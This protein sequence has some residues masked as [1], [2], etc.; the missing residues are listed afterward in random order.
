MAL[1]GGGWWTR[2]TVRRERRS[3]APQVPPPVIREPEAAWWQAHEEPNEPPAEEPAPPAVTVAV[4]REGET[5]EAVVSRLAELAVDD[6]LLV[7]YGS[8]SCS[9]PGHHAVI[10][11]LRGQLPRHHVVAV[12]VR[13]RDGQLRRDDAAALDR[14]LEM[15]SLPVVVA[16]AAFMHGITAE[17]SSYL[18]ADRVLRVLRTTTG[19]DLCQVW[20][21]HPELSV[22]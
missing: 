12:D 11:G 3:P 6:E 14:F 1:H 21:R 8:G 19:A 2:R 4:V 7:V 10:A 18:R 17:I 13:H 22:N 20:S 5:G 9:R 15:G 16:P